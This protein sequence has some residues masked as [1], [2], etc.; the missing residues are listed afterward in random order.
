MCLYVYVLGNDAV[1]YE[2]C[3]V[4]LRGADGWDEGKW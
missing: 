2:K 1:D 4:A 3:S